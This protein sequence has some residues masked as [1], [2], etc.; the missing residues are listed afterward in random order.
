MSYRVASVVASK[1]DAH[2]A[3]HTMYY[4]YPWP[5]LSFDWE[6]YA[7]LVGDEVEGHKAIIAYTETG[8]QVGW[9]CIS[10]VTFDIHVKGMGIVVHHT[11]VDP[12]H[13]A[14]LRVMMRGLQDYC[15][16]LGL[17]WYHITHRTGELTFRSQFHY[18]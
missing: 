6:E 1:G 3:A 13:H 15:R 9:L 4:K 8:V 2:R 16:A 7:G 5:R 12:D 14:A 17:Q 11:V 18:L 10:D